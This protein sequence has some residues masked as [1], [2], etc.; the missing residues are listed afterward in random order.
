MTTEANPAGAANKAVVRRFI[1]EIFEEG[2]VEALDELVTPEFV[3][4]TG[5][6]EDTGRDQLRAAMEESRRGSPTPSSRSMT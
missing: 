2:R 5:P 6:A 3:R 1:E 4:H